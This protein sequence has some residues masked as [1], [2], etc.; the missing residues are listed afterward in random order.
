MVM[1]HIDERMKDKSNI[2]GISP[3]L[4]IAR[5]S[6]TDFKAFRKI[7]EY[8]ISEEDAVPFQWNK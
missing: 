6:K 8:L 3:L 4:K 2:S 5:K 7:V 1:V